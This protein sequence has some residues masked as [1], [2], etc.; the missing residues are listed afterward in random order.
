M[1]GL[2]S[3]VDFHDLFRVVLIKVNKCWMNAIV[4]SSPAM[5]MVLRAG[6]TSVSVKQA[7]DLLA[8]WNKMDEMFDW[9]RKIDYYN[10]LVEICRCKQD[11]WQRLDERWRKAQ[12]DE[13]KKTAV[14]LFVR[15]EL[16]VAIEEINKLVNKFPDIKNSV[17]RFKVN[18]LIKQDAKN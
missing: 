15:D 12:G 17:E 13:A 8:S 11:A 1:A 9:L 7:Q 10:T 6:L 4:P 18:L 5:A 14:R 2:L 16:I 3:D